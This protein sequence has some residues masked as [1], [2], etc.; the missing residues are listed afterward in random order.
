[1]NECLVLINFQSSI[2]D[3]YAENYASN[4]SME[5]IYIP[6][7][8]S[9]ASDFAHTEFLI[10]LGLAISS[11]IFIGTSYIVKKKGLLRLT[12][13]AGDGGHGYLKV[14]S[15]I[16]TPRE[17]PPIWH[18]FDTNILIDLFL[19]FPQLLHYI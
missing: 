3:L 1:M 12:H 4:V 11:S 7:D 9:M 16:G 15:G 2:W 6:T 8:E 19:S 10:G 18:K 17:F 5:L 14:L 13:R